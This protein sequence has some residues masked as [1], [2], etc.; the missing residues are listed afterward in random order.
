MV[1]AAGKNVEKKD[2]YCNQRELLFCDKG[3]AR[4]LAFGLLWHVEITTTTA[5]QK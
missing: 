1:L 2:Q 5:P 4:K 3:G